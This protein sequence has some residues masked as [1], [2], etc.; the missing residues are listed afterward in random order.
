MS[1]VRIVVQTE[2]SG[3]LD[4]QIPALVARMK[5]V[6]ATEP[7]CLQFEFFRS[8]DDPNRL[9]LIE[10]WASM[11][12]YDEFLYRPQPRT[13][14]SGVPLPPPSNRQVEFYKMQVYDL[15]GGEWYPR[16]A[17]YSRTVHWA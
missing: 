3:N 1:G 12:I 15:I 16:D 6:Q 5:Y 10:H 13:A 8:L 7:G 4:E 11:E 2:R 14:T 17:E 9:V